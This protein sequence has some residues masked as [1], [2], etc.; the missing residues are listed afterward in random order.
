MTT[1]VDHE[2]ARRHLTVV[3]GGGMTWMSEMDPLDIV[4]GLLE[5]YDYE[6]AD[7]FTQE[8]IDDRVE[9]AKD[10]QKDELDKD[11]TEE[12]DRLQR[13]HDKA[14]DELKIQH[15]EQI[16]RLTADYEEQISELR[17][18]P[19]PAQAP[20]AQTTNT[21]P[22]TTISYP[23]SPIR[24]E[25]IEIIG[26]SAERP[27]LEPPSSFPSVADLK[28]PAPK[29][30][31]RPKRPIGKLDVPRDVPRRAH[32][33][34]AAKPPREPRVITPSSVGVLPV[35]LAVLTEAGIDVAL[36]VNDIVAR[37]GDRLP[38]KSKT[39]STVV[40]RDLALDIK[41]HGTASRFRRASAGIF[42]LAM[43]H[44]RT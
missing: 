4:E 1:Q 43:D 2:E 24:M 42:R 15:E 8:D 32:E 17:S 5:V 30:A 41:R 3:R 34:G 13:E 12:V 36:S 21:P 11:H 28:L 27:P 29:K 25:T 9:E 33:P 18:E 14:I 7:L 20:E 39:P 10:Q 37:A 35:V 22:P 44:E 19:K 31:D 16:A 6:I 23:T 26:P 40:S 38:T